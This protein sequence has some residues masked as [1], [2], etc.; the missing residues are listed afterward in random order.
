MVEVNLVFQSPMI[1]HLEKIATE[2]ST[3]RDGLYFL[4][5]DNYEVKEPAEI[6]LL[7]QRRP[8]V[9]TGWVTNKLFDDVSLGHIMPLAIPIE[10]SGRYQSHAPLVHSLKT[11]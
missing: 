8:L 3:P 6:Q 1:E 2:G 10:V 5:A 11:H 9:I 4:D 7:M